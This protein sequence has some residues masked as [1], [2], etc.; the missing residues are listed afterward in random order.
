[1]NKGLKS[2]ADTSY[3]QKDELSKIPFLN[4]KFLNSLD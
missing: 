1:M 4:A 3:D 2:L